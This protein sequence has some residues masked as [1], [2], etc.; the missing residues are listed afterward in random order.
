[1]SSHDT[2]TER[3]LRRL[4]EVV[5][6]AR[7]Q[8]DSWLLPAPVLFGVCELVPCTDVGFCLMDVPQRRTV[9][10]VYLEQGVTLHDLAVP[11]DDATEL[12]L[13]EV[14]WDAWAT[15]SGCGY[16]QVSGDH[17]TVL[18]QS[19][20]ISGSCCSATTVRTS[21]SARSCS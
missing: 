20:R 16:P 19:D 21:P 8:R 13:D 1:M 3:D 6:E 9:G 4:L 11:T 7:E 17:T 2:V 18:R 10:G 5:E 15:E 12:A 14:F